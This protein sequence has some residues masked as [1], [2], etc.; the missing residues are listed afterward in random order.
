[1][2]LFLVGCAQKIDLDNAVPQQARLISQ[3][4]MKHIG[5][6]KEFE[7]QRII[8]REPTSGSSLA[9]LKRQKAE[10]ERKI[11][12]LVNLN[13]SNVCAICKKKYN[14]RAPQKKVNA[15][16]KNVRKQREIA[17][18]AAQQVPMQSQSPMLPQFPQAPDQM[19]MPQPLPMQSMPPYQQP[20]PLPQ[21]QQ[22]YQQPPISMPM[23]Y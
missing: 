1:M 19:G 11:A 23:Q 6:D 16:R 2:S 10:L 18:G 7:R 12:R 15:R 14:I 22:Q 9:D 4:H 17:P 8:A 13:N 21:A 5:K 20:L 3:K